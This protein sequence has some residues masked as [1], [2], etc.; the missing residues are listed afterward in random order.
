MTFI[1]TLYPGQAGVRCMD[2]VTDF[3][4]SATAPPELQAASI[5]PA[6]WAVAGASKVSKLL[7]SQH[8]WRRHKH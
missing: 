2:A 6:Q 8:K 7:L 1:V 5:N 3:L 4:T